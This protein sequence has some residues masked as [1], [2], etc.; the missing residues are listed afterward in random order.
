MVNALI[1][2]GVSLGVGMIGSITAVVAIGLTL[3][4]SSGIIWI[5]DRTFDFE[6]ILIEK[7]LEFI[8]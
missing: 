4:I 2:A 5:V 7:M 6:K 3:V 8:D 1:V